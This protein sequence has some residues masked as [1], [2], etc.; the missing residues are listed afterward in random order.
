MTKEYD[1]LLVVR[2][3]SL[4]EQWK[5]RQWKFDDIA[6]TSDQWQDQARFHAKSQ[7]TRDCWKELIELM[8]DE[9]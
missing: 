9:A 6:N 8:K 4:I 2:L 3:S 1:S 5:E 7:A